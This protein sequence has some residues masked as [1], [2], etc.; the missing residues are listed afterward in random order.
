VSLSA[1]PTSSA[2]LRVMG[3]ALAALWLALALATDGVFLS[4]RNLVNLAVQAS[5]VGVMA[6]GMVLVIVARHIDLS[7]GSVLGFTGMVIAALQ[8]E[9]ASRLAPLPWP[10]TLAIGIALAAAIGAWHGAWVAWARVP[11]FVV[12][13]AGLLVFRGAAWLVS[14]GRTL[15]PLDETYTRIGGGLHGAIGATA[16]WGLA[17][18]VAALLAASRLAARRRAREAG[19]A[20]RPFAADALT[21]A[22]PS[23]ALA[24]FVAVA[25]AVPTQGGAAAGLPIPVLV[26]GAVAVARR[27]LHRESSA[28]SPPAAAGDLENPG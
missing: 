25:N 16:S 7:V 12:T 10:A 15:A 14:D 19:L 21:V 13:L 2:R 17:V 22:L 18:A 4:P 1:A 8:V 26:L 5:A 3:A 11:A 23:L 28:E 9:G 20:T 24:G 6:T 27:S